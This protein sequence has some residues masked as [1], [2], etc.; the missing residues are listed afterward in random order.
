MQRFSIRIHTS[1]TR[2]LHYRGVFS[3]SPCGRNETRQR[4]RRSK[5]GI[6]I[7]RRNWLFAGHDEAAS[8]CPVLTTLIAPA[9]RHD[10][11]P[12]AHLTGVL[13]H[14]AALPAT[15]LTSF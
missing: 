5:P 6:A 9:R 12:Q 10:I 7:G 15:T 14:I 3:S 2:G 8:V 4:L 13:A 11:D 1:N